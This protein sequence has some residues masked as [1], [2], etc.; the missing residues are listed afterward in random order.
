[1]KHD[2][3]IFIQKIEGLINLFT[4]LLDALE[5][6]ISP[7]VEKSV[8]ANFELLVTNFE[9]LKN[10]IS[11]DIIDEIDPVVENNI[12]MLID[13]IATEFAMFNINKLNV[14]SDNQT[15]SSYEWLHEIQVDLL[16]EDHYDEKTPGLFEIN[17]N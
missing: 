12:N 15:M 14:D 8:I 7:K 2:K 17:L 6:Q 13:N 1:M 9:L 5:K 16:P 3:K 4:T 11:C 10:V